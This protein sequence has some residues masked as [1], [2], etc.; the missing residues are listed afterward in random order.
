MGNCF[1][2]SAVDS[3]IPTSWPLENDN[4]HALIDDDTLLLHANHHGGAS[5]TVPQAPL[6]LAGLGGSVNG[7]PAAG[8]QRET[9]RSWS[10][11]QFVAHHERIDDIRLG[12][13]DRAAQRVHT[14]NLM[15]QL[16]GILATLYPING[17]ILARN[18]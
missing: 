15:A 2:D 17:P 4:G 10:L 9:T 3:P 5:G 16:D 11:S 13:S 14:H 7:G 18:S 12:R 1:E 6:L 8:D